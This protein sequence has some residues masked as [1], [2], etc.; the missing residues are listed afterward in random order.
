VIDRAGRA[1]VAVDIVANS[2]NVPSPRYI[3][4]TE[5]KT[6]SPI[7]RSVTPSPSASTVPEASALGMS[8]NRCSI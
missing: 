3:L 7:E 8:G 4:P 1:I 6:S 2:A 5:P